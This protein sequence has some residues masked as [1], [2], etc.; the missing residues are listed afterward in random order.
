M[1]Q[2]TKRKVHVIL[3][4]ESVSEIDFLK[5]LSEAEIDLST[6]DFITAEGLTQPINKE[7]AVLV[8]LLSDQTDSVEVQAVVNA[9]AQ[10]GSQ[11]IVGMWAPGQT[12]TAIHPEISKFG[13]AQIPWDSEK[14]KNELGSD[15]ANVFE[16]PEGDPADPNEVDPNECD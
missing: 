3:P 8:V 5:V 12:E 14:L 7:D 2:K 13:T 6:V 15:C 9:A 4:E 1:D 11:Q 16:T 10:A